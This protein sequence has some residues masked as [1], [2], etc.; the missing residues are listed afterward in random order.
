[1][2]EV[3][4]SRK[5]RGSLQ[6]PEK[7]DMSHLGGR[8]YIDGGL[9]YKFDYKVAPGIFREVHDGNL[10]L[11]SFDEVVALERVKGVRGCQKIVGF[12]D[13]VLVTEFIP[14]KNLDVRE[15]IRHLKKPSYTD[16]QLEDFFR[17]LV[18][19]GGRGVTYDQKPK[20]II[21]NAKR[22]FTPID[23]SCTDARQACIMLFPILFGV[24]GADEHSGLFPG[25]AS[26]ELIK[27]EEC[28]ARNFNRMLRAFHKADPKI[29]IQTVRGGLDPKDLPKRFR[30]E[31]DHKSAVYIEM[32]GIL[33]EKYNCRLED[34][35]R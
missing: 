33:G 20:N 23:Y 27:D 25:A 19:M 16:Q 10:G 4:L 15:G 21:F 26:G 5:D 35:V 18:E 30:K 1:M 32:Q 22:G 9:V 7:T 24:S 17:T 12:A 11:T 31:L 6:I 34:L 2:R 29:A 3:Y 28:L 14:G 8:T 13:Q